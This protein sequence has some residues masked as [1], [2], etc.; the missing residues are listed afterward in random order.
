MG[1][2][3][4]APVEMNMLRQV[5]RALGDIDC[6]RGDPMKVYYLAHCLRDMVARGDRSWSEYRP[7]VAEEFE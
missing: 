1:G 3:N 6:A 2:G 5:R 4:N 7:M